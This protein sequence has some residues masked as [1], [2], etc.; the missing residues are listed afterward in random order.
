M[1]LLTDELGEETVDYPSTAIHLVG[2]GNIC[3]CPIN[4]FS[5][6]SIIEDINVITILL[7]NSFIKLPKLKLKIWGKARAFL[8]LLATP[9]RE[10]QIWNIISS[11]QRLENV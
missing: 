1:K 8:T 10:K 2:S 11:Q 9:S 3:P 6:I 7:Y 5:D 4:I